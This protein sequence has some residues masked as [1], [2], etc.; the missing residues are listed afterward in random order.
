[1]TEQ[2]TTDMNHPVTKRDLVEKGIEALDLSNAGSMPVQHQPT[3]GVSR[4]DIAQV[5]ELGKIMA[6]S[7]DAVP[8]HCRVN[9]GICVRV[10][11]QAVEWGMSPFQVA[12]QTYVVNNRLA[13]MSQILHAVIE[14]RAPLRSR[15]DCEYEGE[16]QDMKCTVRGVFK[17]G[18][19]REYESPMVK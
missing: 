16:G 15:L 1:M 3:G 12:D 8:L 19:V 18:D 10:C 9:V 11:F 13:Y 5:I 14:G 17:T 4:V 7:Q 6:A 2:E